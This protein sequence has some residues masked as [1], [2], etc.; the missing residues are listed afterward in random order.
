EQGRDAKPQDIQRIIQDQGLAIVSDQAEIQPIIEA[1]LA[2]NTP[3][4]TDFRN[5]KQGAVGPLIG[6]A[7]RQ[8]QGADPQ[9]V[10]QMLIDAM[11]D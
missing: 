10:R 4:V 11:S 2:N 5:G 6:Q 8:I 7:M 9:T 3:A 1:I